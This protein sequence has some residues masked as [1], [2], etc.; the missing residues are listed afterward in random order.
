MA[1]S[2]RDAARAALVGRTDLEPRLRLALE[3]RELGTVADK[4]VAEG[5][6]ATFE[7]GSVGTATGR[8]LVRAR[9]G[10]SPSASPRAVPRS[11]SSRPGA[12]SRAC[13]AGRL[14]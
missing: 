10:S 14:T 5:V 12:S 11:P 6:L 4:F 3:R 7:R 13:S 8:I 9:A 1:R 2:E